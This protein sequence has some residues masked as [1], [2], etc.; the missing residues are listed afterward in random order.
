M[1]DKL[2]T[3]V[4]LVVTLCS[5]IPFNH[6]GVWLPSITK[7]C[8]SDNFPGFHVEHVH[9]YNTIEMSPYGNNERRVWDIHPTP[10]FTV[11]F[12]Y[13]N[14]EPKHDFITVNG[15]S[16]YGTNTP[17]IHPV[18][19]NRR[20]WEPWCVLVEFSSDHSVTKSGFRFHVIQGIVSEWHT[21][22]D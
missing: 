2:M 14:L 21:I 10:P 12:D 8:G 22:V 17:P 9:G 5:I 19:R 20:S 18:H 1:G 3:T 15:I 16:Y 13:L 4:L 7:Q 11:V 6:G